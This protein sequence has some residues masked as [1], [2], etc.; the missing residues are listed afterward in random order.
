[1]GEGVGGRE[2]SDGREVDEV[3]GRS[4]REREGEKNELTKRGGGG[5]KKTREGE[6]GIFIDIP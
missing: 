1:M 3:E 5:K 6:R 4:G 2:R